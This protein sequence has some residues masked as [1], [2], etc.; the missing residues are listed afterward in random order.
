MRTGWIC[1]AIG[2]EEGIAGPNSP[3]INK[4]PRNKVSDLYGFVLLSMSF[5]FEL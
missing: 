4:R 1:S 5:S 3:V 2:E